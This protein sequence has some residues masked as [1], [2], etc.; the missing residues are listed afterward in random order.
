M[1]TI[2]KAILALL[3]IMMPASVTAQEK[4]RETAT[5]KY[6]TSIDCQNCVNTIMKN[7]PFEKGVRDVTCN[8]QT[9]VVTI[10]YNPDKTKPELLKRALEKLGYT[11]KE[12]AEKTKEPGT[13]N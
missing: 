3:I 11:A 13:N 4:G 9:K 7:L 1:K 8:L 12:I 5:V 10:K 2:S 6:D